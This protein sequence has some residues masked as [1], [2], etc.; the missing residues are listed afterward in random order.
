M[1]KILISKDSLDK[2]IQV[3][4]NHLKILKSGS[5]SIDPEYQDK[6]IESLEKLESIKDTLKPVSKMAKEHLRTLYS[7]YL[8]LKQKKNEAY[9]KENWEEYNRLKEE[10]N[11]KMEQYINLKKTIGELEEI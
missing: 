2:A 3:I 6:V 4:D 5:V 1:E 8:K 7:Q 11:K 9:K 10:A